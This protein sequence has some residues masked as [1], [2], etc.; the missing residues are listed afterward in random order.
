LCYATF[1]SQLRALSARIGVRVT[2]HMFRHALAQALVDTAGLKVAQEL[3]GHAHVSTTAAAYARVDE[4]AM[5]DALARVGDLFELSARETSMAPQA[6]GRD[7]FV[8]A[9]DPATAATL[10]A[11]AAGR[12]KPAR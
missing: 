9:Y 1:E 11:A 2:A 5:V 10:D 3:L 12:A 6:P 4:R 7:A 8:F